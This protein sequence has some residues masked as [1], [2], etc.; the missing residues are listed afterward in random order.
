MNKI[1][2]G[3]SDQADFRRGTETGNLSVFL[4]KILGK[5]FT[6]PGVETDG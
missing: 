5:K 4:Y 3:P 1:K 6:S 2:R